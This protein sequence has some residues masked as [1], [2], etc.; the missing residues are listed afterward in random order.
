MDDIATPSRLQQRDQPW[1]QLKH[2][3]AEWDVAWVN[4]VFEVYHE[5]IAMAVLERSE[6]VYIYLIYSRPVL[7]TLSK[8][9]SGSPSWTLDFSHTHS[10]WADHLIDEAHF[11]Q[12]ANVSNEGSSD[13]LLHFHEGNLGLEIAASTVDTIFRL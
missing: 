12:W 8:M 1:D 13:T 9:N 6:T 3:C 4:F 7:G 11:R 5:A 2:L 10:I